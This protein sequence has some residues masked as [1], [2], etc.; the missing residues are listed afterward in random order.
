MNPVLL[1]AVALY[2]LLLGT[3]WLSLRK[4][5][6]TYHPLVRFGI[7][8]NLFILGYYLVSNG[9]M[10][11]VMIVVPASLFIF[12]LGAIRLVKHWNELTSGQS[13]LI[14]LLLLSPFPLSYCWVVLL[15]EIGQAIRPITKATPS[16]LL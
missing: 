7:G 4:S 2:G 16:S 1:I 15:A 9:L 5:Y 6:R 10:S 12:L 8:S 3:L 11:Y 13:T 14:S